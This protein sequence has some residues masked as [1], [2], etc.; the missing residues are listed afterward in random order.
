MR[1][2]HNCCIKLVR[3]VILDNIVFLNLLGEKS[4]K[5][6]RRNFEVDGVG[7]Q[8]YVTDNSWIHS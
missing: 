3:L 4:D 2:N 1:I 8:S 6:Q 7:S 5:I